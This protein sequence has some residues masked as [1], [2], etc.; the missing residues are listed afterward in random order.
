MF[1][2]SFFDY[3]AYQKPSG[4]GSTLKGRNLLP[5]QKDIPFKNRPYLKKIEIRIL[6]V[7]SPENISSPLKINLNEMVLKGIYDSN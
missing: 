4:K 3:Q 5:L 7:A 1:V 6:R 2:T